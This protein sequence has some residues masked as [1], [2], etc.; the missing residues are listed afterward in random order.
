MQIQKFNGVICPHIK[1]VWWFHIITLFTWWNNDG[2][3]EH[4]YSRRSRVILTGK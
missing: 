2:D 4:A 1:L 3:G